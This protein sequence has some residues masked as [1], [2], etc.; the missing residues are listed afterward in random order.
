MASRDVNHHADRKAREDGEIPTEALILRDFGGI[1]TQV[2]RVSI[3]DNEFYWLENMMPVGPGALAQVPGPVAL[4]Y[5]PSAAVSYVYHA[6]WGNTDYAVVFYADGS[7][8]AL[9]L[10]TL[11]R[12]TVGSPGTFTAAS[13]APWN[14]QGIVIIDA[15]NGYFD[16]SITTA[17]TLTPQ[18]NGIASVTNIF[19]KAYLSGSVAIATSIVTATGTGGSVVSQYVV[20]SATISAAGS[21]YSVGDIL[22]FTDN[23]PKIAPQFQVTSINAGGAITGFSIINAGLLQTTGAPTVLGPSGVASS[24]TGIGAAFTIWLKFSS[25]VILSA[26]SKYSAADPVYTLAPGPNLYDQGKI[27]TSGVLNGT[28]IAVYAGR[29][30]IANGK[31]VY[32]TDVGSYNSFG[33]AGGSFII[34]DDWLNGSI[35]AL[36]AANN[37]LY[38]FGQDSIDVLS[39][40]NIS[41]L[42]TTTFSRTNLTSSI[43]TTLPNSIFAFYRSVYFASK[44][45]LYALSGATPQRISDHLDGVLANANLDLPVSGA[46]VFVKSKLCVAFQFTFTDQWFQVGTIRSALFVLTGSKWFVVSQS[47]GQAL[48][49]WT[50]G[51]AIAT[52]S[53]STTNAQMVLASENVITIPV[54]ATKLWDY[55]D[56]LSDKQAVK[57]SILTTWSSPSNLTPGMGCLVITEYNTAGAQLKSYE[58]AAAWVNSSN[59]IIPWTNIAGTR[60]QWGA[61]APYSFL[62]GVANVANGKHIGLTFL[63]VQ[64]KKLVVAQIALD[65]KQMKSW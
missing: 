43:G 32:Y 63:P 27:T 14:N 31:T 50:N 18:T 8:D 33:G 60:V 6:N 52:I 29:V 11:A 28:S 44:T 40:V 53:F 4:G 64:T 3:G 41:S 61:S 21:G 10:S 19:N 17:N 2:P 34:Q 9:N 62:A 26:G 12:T 13:I 54:I 22:N 24:G 46:P 16:F 47:L 23:S 37:F 36:F 65:A 7:A 35:T 42:G 5:T 57:A 49:S 20:N 45:G 25:Y 51:G 38:I 59:Q 55:G 1:N 58:S 15:A 48:V 39:N 56:P 30:W